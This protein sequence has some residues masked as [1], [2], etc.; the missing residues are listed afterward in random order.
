MWVSN[1]CLIISDR[2][3]GRTEGEEGNRRIAIEDILKVMSP[4]Q[5]KE[6]REETRLW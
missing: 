3:D 2:L 4:E 6:R 1:N 5:K